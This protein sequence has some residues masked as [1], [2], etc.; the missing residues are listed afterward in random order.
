[1]AG[2]SDAAE[3]IQRDDARQYK[4]LPHIRCPHCW[5]R[6]RSSEIV[7]VA[8]H[9]ELRGD[10]V[11]GGDYFVRFRPSR[12]NVAGEALDARGMS[13]QTLA[14]PRCH[15][16]IPLAFLECEPLIFSLI[17]VMASGKS[18]FLAA[19][20]WELRQM[21]KSRFGLVFTDADAVGN[22]ILNDYEKMLFL[23]ADLDQLVALRKTELQGDLYDIINLE[24][25]QASLP[26]PFLFTMRPSA[27]HP[28]A[29]AAEVLSRIICLYDNAGEHFQPDPNMDSLTAPGTQHLARARI[30]MFLFDP[31]QDP[32]TRD[33]CKNVSGD[34]QLFEKART[35]RQALILTEAVLRVRRHA[36]LAPNRKLDKPLLVLVSKADI[37]SQLIDEDLRVEPHVA[38]G[39]LPTLVDTG[40]IEAVSAKVRKFLMTQVPEFV[41]VAEDA[42]KSVTY[43]PVSA[44]GCSPEPLTVG[45]GLGI[46]P[47]DIAP[48]WVTVPML[49]SFAR[50]STSLVEATNGSA[51]APPEA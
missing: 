14:C 21:L 31:T 32:R 6:F 42:C 16:V 20:T 35:E 24:G 45:T 12:F 1:M 44:L 41:T 30:L 50:W 4:L 17:G 22:Q 13:C 3:Q 5:L 27:E 43:I 46:R 39:R 10:L 8:R 34:P 29:A 26:R 36:G 2:E 25:Q 23:Q 49:Y 15:L 28:S 51:A 48:R 37:W 18:Y 38:R 9:E 19:M 33:L 7:W 47:K 40:R 11:L